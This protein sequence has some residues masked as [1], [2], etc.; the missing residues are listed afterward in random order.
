MDKEGKADHKEEDEHQPFLGFSFLKQ[1]NR[2]GVLGTVNLNRGK[3]TQ[4]G[5]GDTSET[6][7]GKLDAVKSLGSLEID[8]W[9][10]ESQTRPSLN[11]S[12]YLEELVKDAEGQT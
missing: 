2:D 8:P 9:V 5:M 12:F 6:Y 3:R 10:P 7:G 4:A 11:F 1:V